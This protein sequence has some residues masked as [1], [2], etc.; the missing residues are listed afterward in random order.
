MQD[1]NL[2]LFNDQIKSIEELER[3]FMDAFADF[4]QEF[5]W[6]FEGI[7][8]ICLKLERAKAISIVK[9]IWSQYSFMFYKTL[10]SGTKRESISV[11]YAL[12]QM[13]NLSAV[14]ANNLIQNFNFNLKLKTSW[15]ISRKKCTQ[16]HFPYEEYIKEYD[17]RSLFILFVCTLLR[18]SE[19]Q[20][21]QKFVSQ[22]KAVIAQVFPGLEK[23]TEYIQ[24]TFLETLKKYVIDPDAI[25]KNSKIAIL[26]VKHLEKIAFLNKP[27]SFGF[28]KHVCTRPGHGV[29]YQDM[30]WYPPDKEKVLCSE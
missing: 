11:L 29:C 19:V 23:D 25:P 10:T 2:Q 26:Q 12:I 8:L 24:Q 22:A 13:G 20:A 27:F 3:Q 30:G 7:S 17:T 9:N 14:I 4:N 16:L 28:L 1:L 18:K 15:T 21:R 6:K 5:L